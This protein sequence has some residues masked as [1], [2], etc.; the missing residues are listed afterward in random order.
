MTTIYTHHSFPEE[1][2]YL[3]SYLVLQRFQQRMS[4]IMT[5]MPFL[6][7]TKSAKAL[8]QTQRNQP[9]NYPY[10]GHYTNQPALAGT[11]S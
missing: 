8:K 1:S 3:P 2:Y 11:S 10:Y 5:G 4:G 7:A 9:T 6:S